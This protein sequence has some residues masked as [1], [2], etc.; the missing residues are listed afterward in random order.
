MCF[1][2]LGHRALKQGQHQGSWPLCP[3]QLCRV[4]GARLRGLHITTT[5]SAPVVSSLLPHGRTATPPLAGALSNGAAQQVHAGEFTL[6]P[7]LLP[8]PRLP[9]ATW[10]P[11]KALRLLEAMRAHPILRHPA[12]PP[13]DFKHGCRLVSLAWAK[14]LLSRSRSCVAGNHHPFQPPTLTLHS[15]SFAP[16]PYEGLT[17]NH[18]L[19]QT[20]TSPYRCLCHPGLPGL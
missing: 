18:C 1:L 4:H 13:E 19:E 11:L 8:Q 10:G 20:H 9:K 15:A 2:Y 14:T 16:Q 7:T 17:P 5:P 12:N 3:G 6:N